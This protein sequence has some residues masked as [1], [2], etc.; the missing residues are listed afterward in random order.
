[1]LA[2]IFAPGDMWILLIVGGLFVGVPAAIILLVVLAG[3]NSSS[4]SQLRL[5]CRVGI[6]NNLLPELRQAFGRTGGRLHVV[7]ASAVERQ[8][9]LPDL[10]C[11]TEPGRHR[12]CEMRSIDKGSCGSGRGY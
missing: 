5:A 10:R 2:Y 1:M 3:K 8:Q 9:I 11:G 12:L 7:R 4:D 6:D